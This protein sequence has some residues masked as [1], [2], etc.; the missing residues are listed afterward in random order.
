MLKNNNE[1]A[2]VLCGHGSSFNL[3]IN[4]F[5]KNQKII[6][7][8]IYTSCYICFIEKNEPNIEDCL[9]LIKKKGVKKVIFFPFLLFNGEHFEH[10]IKFKIGELSKSLNLKIKLIEKISLTE[11]VMPMIEK[12]ISKL[13]IKNKTSIL[14]TFCSRSKNPKMCSEHKKYTQKIAKNLNID[15]A[16]SYFVGEETKFIEKIKNLKIENYVLII[17]PIFLFKGYLQNTNMSFFNKLKI[18][19]YHVLNTLMTNKDIQSLVVK[20]LKST[21]HITN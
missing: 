20:K 2:I 15:Q 16:Y 6:E 9:R 8:K 17:Q 21:F 3:Y 11:D 5:K 10:D 12:K 1:I 14:A 4:D 19:N 18:K 7:E 13:I